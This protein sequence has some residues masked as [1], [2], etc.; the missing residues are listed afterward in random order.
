[1]GA[2]EFN[3]LLEA[4]SNPCRVADIV[5]AQRKSEDM[6]AH[7]NQWWALIDRLAITCHCV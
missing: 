1:V 6:A 5:V 4:K 3:L 7:C 2:V